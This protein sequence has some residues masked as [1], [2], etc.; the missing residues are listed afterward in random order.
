V[1]NGQISKS[2]LDVI[3]L[4]CFSAFCLAFLFTLVSVAASSPSAFAKSPSNAGASKSSNKPVPKKQKSDL[5]EFKLPKDNYNGSDVSPTSLIF[6]YSNMVLADRG[7]KIPNQEDRMRA[8]LRA[9]VKA[10]GT[11]PVSK[12]LLFAKLLEET[13]HDFE[14]ANCLVLCRELAKLDKTQSRHLPTVVARLAAITRKIEKAS[15]NNFDQW[16]PNIPTYSRA[17]TTSPVSLPGA[18]LFATFLD[19]LSEPMKD[20]PSTGILWLDRGKLFM[21]YGLYTN[22]AKDFLLAKSKL[23]RNDTRPL[24]NLALC[25]FNMQDIPQTLWCAQSIIAINKNS[26]EGHGARALGLIDKPERAIA[27]C[28]TAI[29][30]NPKIG[31]FYTTRAQIREEKLSEWKNA[32]ADCTRALEINSADPYA[33]LLRAR[34]YN[35]LGKYQLAIEDLTAA[36]NKEPLY[37]EAYR[38]RAE[39]YSELGEK[40]LAKQ[41]RERYERYH[42]WLRDS[43]KGN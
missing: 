24:V 43:L 7:N 14:C 6:I 18:T 26:A 38:T 20:H 13:N 2:T 23:D 36:V 22:A 3:A 16:N 17:T 5:I 39:S 1:K 10:K 12:L 4:R 37:F 34:A 21:R 40:D 31:W 25:Y 19:R 8:S 33:R 32:V 42:G 29:K 41:D 9:E 28:D 35:E 15:T 30:L 27:E 11:V